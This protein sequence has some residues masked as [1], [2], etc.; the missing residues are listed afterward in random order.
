MAENLHTLNPS[1]NKQKMTSHPYNQKKNS[2]SVKP[3]KSTNGTKLTPKQ[4]QTLNYTRRINSPF[5]PNLQKATSKSLTIKKKSIC[6]VI[7]KTNE[8]AKII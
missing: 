3:N 6:L 1:A 4:A 7:C 5:L 2:H 8:Q